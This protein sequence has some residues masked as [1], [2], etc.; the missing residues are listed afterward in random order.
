MA[1]QKVVTRFDFETIISGV[2]FMIQ[3]PEHVERLHK[4][5]E[6]SYFFLGDDNIQVK[7]LRRILKT[8]EEIRKET[9]SASISVTYFDSYLRSR[10]MDSDEQQAAIALFQ[11]MIRDQNIQQKSIDR[12]CQSIFLDFVKCTQM[13]KWGESFTPAYKAGRIPEAIKG[14]KEVTSTLDQIRFTDSVSAIDVGQMS[15]DDILNLISAPQEGNKSVFLIGHPQIDDDI[16]GF[17]KKSLHLFIGATGSGKSMMTHH[18]LARSIE[19]RL[20]AH[21]A[22][23]ED[24]P[25]SFMRRLI[26]CVTGIDLN[27]LR[28]KR[29]LLTNEEKNSIKLAQQD[30]AKYIKIEFIYGESLDS[31]HRKKIEYDAERIA[32]GLD[33]YDVDIVDYTGHIAEK[34]RGDKT[35]EK[36]RNAYA[37]RKDFALINNKITFDF[38]QVNRGG[39]QKKEGGGALN[40]GDL[41]GSYDLSQVCDNI[42]T[43][44]VTPDEKVKN[45][46]RLCLTKVRDGVLNEKGHKI[47]INFRC[48]RYEMRKHYLVENQNQQIDQSQTMRSDSNGNET[49]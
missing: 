7:G 10:L 33:Q 46:A 36:M 18:L 27:R 35:Y 5:I 26:A 31:I 11:R 45:D 23:V 9:G 42:I 20:T 34:D 24:K 3:H 14:M 49:L 30:I 4:Y 32:K 38:A 28:Y 29:N 43:I 15:V 21:V 40:H 44:N 47:G 6:P 39:F 8:I 37:S 12:G 1:E 25:Q 17:E 22:I 16:G 2:F 13:M 41:A 48:A 19:Q